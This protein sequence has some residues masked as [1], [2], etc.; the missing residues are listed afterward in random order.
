MNERANTELYLNL[1]SSRTVS[2]YT[3]ISALE[4][5]QNCLLHQDYS[6][7]QLTL[8]RHYAL[9]RELEFLELEMQ[10]CRTRS[11][12]FSSQSVESL[13]LA[14]VEMGRALSALRYANHVFAGVLRRFRRSSNIFLLMAESLNTTYTALQ[15]ATWSSESLSAGMGA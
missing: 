7:F 5:S 6:G 1:L 3:L 9:C 10:T 12:G 2:A 14:E 15:P 11:C 4:D 8:E 13:R